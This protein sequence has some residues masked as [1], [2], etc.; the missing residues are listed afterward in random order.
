[1]LIEGIVGSW[2]SE[3]TVVASGREYFVVLDG[4]DNKENL[5]EF[6]SERATIISVYRLYMK[7]EDVRVLQ[8]A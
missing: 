5:L 3:S 8:L 2:D 7:H 6:S 4:D 1:V